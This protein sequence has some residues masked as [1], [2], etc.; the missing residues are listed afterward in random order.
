MASPSTD[1]A[2]RSRTPWL[3]VAAV[4]VVALVLAISIPSLRGG[5]STPPL[6]LSLGPDDALA[7]CIA[8]DVAILAEMPVAFEGTVTA[9]AGEQVT[10]TVDRWFKGGDADTVELSAPAGM[11][12]LIGGIAF[13]EGDRYLITA[14]DGAVNYCGFSGPA[15]PELTAAFEQAFAG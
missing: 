15:T 2:Q 5:P 14:T 7:S 8:F 9:V 6:G 11:E 10:L 12:A 13:V 4:A 1:T 3:A